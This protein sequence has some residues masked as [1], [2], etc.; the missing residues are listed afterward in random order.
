MVVKLFRS[1]AILLGCL[2]LLACQEVAGQST[3]PTSPAPVAKPRDALERDTPRGTVLG[4][5]AAGRAHNFE[6]AAQYLNTGLRGNGAA[7]LAE[8]LYVILDRRLPPRLNQLSDQP[9]GSSSGPAEPDQELV[10]TI[11]SPNGDIDILLERLD[12]RKT[13]PLWFFAKKT[14]DSVPA[15]YQEVNSVPIEEL[16]PKF[17]VET[18]LFGIAL[19]EW[20][21]L[22]VG[23]PAAYLFTVFFGRALNGL[24]GLLRR[25]W[26][27]SPGLPNPQLLP[28][29]L[30]LLIM[31]ILIRWICAKISMR[32]LER[33]F[34]TSIAVLILIAAF[35][36]LV[37]MLIGW[38]ERTLLK[39]F[40]R[41]NLSGIIPIMRFGRRAAD[42]LVIVAGVMAALGYF[43]VN[44]TAALAGL[45]V[46]GIA[47]AL[48]AQKTLENVI[49][50]LSLIF[51]KTVSLGDFLKVSGTQGTVDA[52]GLRSTRIRTPDRTVVSVPNG[53]MATASLENCSARDKFWLNHMVGLRYET[54]PSQLRAVLE[55]IT[56][57]LTQ[58]PCIEN[59]SIRARF[60]RFGT[61]SLDIEIVAYLFARDWNHF[62]EIQEALLLGIMD[63]VERAGTRIAIPSQ[64]LYMAQ[65]AE[66]N[67][68]TSLPLHAAAVT[69]K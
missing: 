47:V 18:R 54:T 12:Q 20:L 66:T 30:R 4:F 1:P 50:G 10:G 3:A 21:G 9:E 59:D 62:L 5:L 57:L 23:L 60:L 19:L 17:L 8:Q 48:A 46:G 26:K 33:Q 61:A 58:S 11:R 51:D 25:R 64:T 68:A 28:A 24:V 34:W 22:I 14:L 37:R 7:R 63:T 35:V 65:S 15:L 69:K 52:I 40:G 6:V 44:L 38:G 45:G 16:A 39:R 53:Q 27:R 2:G 36:W 29:P 42:L 31:A 32:L 41:R 13:G 67:G 49:G 56:Y 55:G 43:G